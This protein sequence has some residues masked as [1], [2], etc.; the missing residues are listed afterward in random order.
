MVNQRAVQMAVTLARWKA[1]W[2]VVRWVG[3]MVAP[4]VDLKGSHWVENSVPLTVESKA[5]L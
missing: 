3:S 2:R 1:E 4:K 5:A